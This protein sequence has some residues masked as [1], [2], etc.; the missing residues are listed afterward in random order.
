M[1]IALFFFAHWWGSVFFQT[2]FHHRYAS[3]R[4]FTMGP[5]TERVVHFLAY[6]FQGSSYLDVRAYALLHREHHAFSDTVR[7]PH[8]PTNHGNVMSMMMATNERY[9]GYAQRKVEP[10]ARFEGGIPE[11]P[12]MDKLG[13]SWT[14]RLGWMAAYTAFY[15]VFATA[16]W[17]FL[18]LPVHF[19]MGPV[20]GAIVNW[21]G[22]TLGYR[23]F[24]SRDQSRNTLAFDF[25]TL[26]ELFQN[27]HHH[28][29]RNANFARRWFEVD[30]AY[31]LMRVMAKL[32]IIRLVVQPKAVVAESPEL[33]EPDAAHEYRQAS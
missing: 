3:H 30:P 5:R 27:N 26:G 24:S 31:Q 10:E 19:A 13:R 21:W 7:D 22:H 23:N 18:L 16:W 25:L 4:M 28:A 2:L 32:G 11:W 14:M 15:L 17:Q 8:S 12:L 1:A 9:Q 20:H 29:S 6:M 33:G